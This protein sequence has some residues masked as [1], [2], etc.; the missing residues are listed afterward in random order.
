MRKYL[1]IIVLIPLFFACTPAEKK[2]AVITGKVDNMQKEFFFMGG[3]GGARD[4]VF[5]DENGGFTYNLP[6]LAEPTWYYILDGN[7]YFRMYINPGAELDLYFDGA[8]FK[9]SL[10]FT[11][12]GSDIMNYLVAKMRNESD[13]SP[14]VFKLDEN[15]F[16]FQ[17]DSMLAVQQGIYNESVKEDATDIFWKTEEAEILFGWASNLTNYPSYHSYYADVTDFT[18]SD[19]FYS[20]ESQLNLNNPDYIKSSAFN[21]YLTTLIRKKASEKVAEMKKADSTLVPKTGLISMEIAS[22]MITETAIL[23]N[24][25]SSTV[26]NAVQWNEISEIQDQ[27]DYFLNHC[28]DT[29]LVAKFN[30]TLGEW[31]LLAAGQPMIDFAGKDL[32]GNPVSSTDLRG[33]YLYVDVWATW[34][35]PCKYEIPFLKQLE[36]DYHGRNIVFLSYSIDEDHDAWLK[37]VPENELG[38]VQIIG[39]NAWESALCTN[40]KIRGVPTFMFFDPAG[41]IISV[42]MTRPSNQLT[43]DK[44]DSYSDL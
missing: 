17:A 30:K 39:E 22:D 36:K 29:A 16:R 11:G 13:G 5:L 6:D 25:L 18:V 37:F 40:Y 34:C 38:G 42:K 35:G 24:Y 9:E 32:D 7:N 2:G 19:E 12:K 44:F 41:K 10:G 8:S 33:K 28:K 14:E 4:S 3:P 21:N 27:I 15:A 43:R 26:S 1:I 20:F 23:N 31:K